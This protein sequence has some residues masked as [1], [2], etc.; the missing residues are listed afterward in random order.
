MNRKWKRYAALTIFG[1]ALLVGCGSGGSSSGSQSGTN[2]SGEPEQTTI[3]WMNMLHSA[4]PPTDTITNAVEEYTNTQLEFQWIPDASKEERLNTALASGNLAD[5]VTLTIMENSSVR[6]ALKAG[7][8]WDVEPY[9]DDFENLAEISEETRRSASIEGVLYGIPFQK[10]LARNGV[11]LRRDWLENLGMEE[12]TTV[13]ELFEVARAFTE[14]DP[15]GSGQNDTTGFMDRA[16]LKYGAFKTLA[17]YHGVPNEWKEENGAFTPQFDTPEYIEAMDYMR[18]LYAGG[19]INQDFAVT[20]KTDQQESF[21]QGRAGIYVG[22]LMDAVNLYTLA[23]G[24]QDDMDLAQLNKINKDGSDEY[25][26]WSDNNGIG[27]LLAF[28]RSEVADEDELRAVLQ[29]VN[30]LHDEEVYT[31]M[32]SGIEGVHHEMDGNVSTRLDEDLWQQ[33]VQPFSSSRPKEIGYDIVT[34][35]ELKL[36]SDGLILENEEIAVLNPAYSLESNTFTSQGSELSVAIDDATYQYIL[37]DI[38]LDDFEAV[39]ERWY[40]SGGQQ[41]IEEYEAAFAEIQE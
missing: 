18:A 17:T 8:F 6:N 1:S 37:G 30:D 31:L 13:E 7:Q 26:I 19:M 36:Y 12:P 3:S 29:F 15:N 9:L 39:V 14:D 21:A 41:I 40:S 32:S 33:E 28:P 11:I 16:D 20:A 34:G 4:S 10:P 25:A 2:A 35:N 23:E 22:G 5:I 38:D 24:I 27:G